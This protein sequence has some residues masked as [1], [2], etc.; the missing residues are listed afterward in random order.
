MSSPWFD[1]VLVDGVKFE[2]SN[3]P[4]LNSSFTVPLEEMN[5]KFAFIADTVA[6]S[7]PHEISYSVEIDWSKLQKD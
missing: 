5:D 2:P 3:E 4:G 1:Y 7:E 6:M